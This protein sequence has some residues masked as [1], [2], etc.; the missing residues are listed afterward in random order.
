MMNGTENRSDVTGVADP[1]WW[2]RLSAL[3]VRR[4]PFG[5][6]RAA[7]WIVRARRHCHRRAADVVWG[8]LPAS[9]GGGA[10]LACDLRESISREVFFNG[11]YEPLEVRILLSILRPGMCFVDV[12]ANRGYFTLLAAVRV[13]R[14]GR[15]MALEPDPRMYEALAGAVREN[16]LGQVTALPYAA[17]ESSGHAAL[18]GFDE[19]N[20]NFGTSRVADS[21]DGPGEQ[22]SVTV[23]PLDDVL[24]EQGWKDV[25]LIKMDI[26]GYEGFALRGFTTMLANN[27][28]GRLLVE[29][30]PEQLLRHGHDAKRVMARLAA[31]GYK[32][33]FLDHSARAYRAAAYGRHRMRD[34]VRPLDPAE[35]LGRWP[36]TLWV[37]R[38][39]D[40]SPDLV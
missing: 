31:Y 20:G 12:G 3:G 22:F 24:A 21:A 28:V 32:G 8:R 18:I 1:E 37:R 17:G 27:R 5:R 2:L 11:V 29:F 19:S 40:W 26:E 38:D 35:D 15:V 7:E 30:H 13:G 16:G 23:R 14:S 34:F 36:H 39:V 9:A 10:R 33:W 4:L 25:D 6:F